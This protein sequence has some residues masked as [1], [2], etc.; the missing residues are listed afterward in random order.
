MTSVLLT[1]V[2]P[3]RTLNSLPARIKTFTSVSWNTK[4]KEQFNHHCRDYVHHLKEES[5]LRSSLPEKGLAY[6]DLWQAPKYYFCFGHAEQR[7]HSQERRCRK[8]PD[9]VW[10][11]QE[12]KSQK[13]TKQNNSYFYGKFVWKTHRKRF[14]EQTL[15]SS[16]S[17]KYIK[18]ASLAL[19]STFWL[20]D[21]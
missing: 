12:L 2:V 18:R 21:R 7:N 14:N 11:K 20:I 6:L 4:D 13:I 8:S 10:R 9:R 1:S 16:S 17:P 19:V 3:T 5:Q 15:T